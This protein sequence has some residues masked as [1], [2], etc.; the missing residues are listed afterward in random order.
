MNRRLKNLIYRILVSLFL[1]SN[2][3][4]AFESRELFARSGGLAGSYSAS[5]G[6]SIC[7]Y[8][9]PAGLFSLPKY[10]FLF[11]YT[12]PY[13]ISNLSDTTLTFATKVP[14][15]GNVGIL[16]NSFGFDLYKEES[17]YFAYSNNLVENFSAGFTLKYNSLAIKSYG[18]KSLLGLDLGFSGVLS[19]SAVVSLVI[20]NVNNPEID[21]REQLEKETVCGA[22]LEVIKKS[23]TYVDVVKPVFG[24]IYLKVGQEVCFNEYLTFRAGVETVAKDK[25]SKYGLGFSFTYRTISF[26]FAN[27]VH[28][29]LSD[30]YIFSLNIQ[31]GNKE[32]LP[33]IEDISRYSRTR[34]SRTKSSSTKRKEFSGKKINLNT[35]TVEETYTYC[36]ILCNVILPNRGTSSKSSTLLNLPNNFLVSTIR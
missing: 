4:S 15:L 6:E 20:K 27:V 16:W 31:I 11:S 35:A 9:N 29:Y 19:R 30:Q 32:P 8:Y 26:D 1:C 17:F 21:S 10:D 14:S 7:V 23:P 13:N 5:Y 33:E 36:F 24:E 28:P 22:R 18:G 2:L 3:F 25:P 12:N 34:S